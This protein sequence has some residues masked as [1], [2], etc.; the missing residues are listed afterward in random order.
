MR[1]E[2]QARTELTLDALRVLADDNRWQGS[3]LADRIDSSAAY[4]AHIIAPLTR[5]N[6][7]I[8][9]PGPRGGYELAVDLDQMSMH[10]LIELVEGPTDSGRCVMANRPCLAPEPCA[11]HDAWTRART[12]LTNEL[13]SISLGQIINHQEAPK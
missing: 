5:A 7:V 4:V 1:L 6:W 11:L 9:L 13:D 12:A 10:D 2:L 3:A 8:S